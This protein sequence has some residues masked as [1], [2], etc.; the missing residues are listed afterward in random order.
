MGTRHSSAFKPGEAPRKRSAAELVEVRRM[1]AEA[2]SELEHL[3]LTTDVACAPA[4]HIGASLG[5][6]VD[7]LRQTYLECELSID[8]EDPR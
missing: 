8:R 2:H 7:E 3:R 4:K 6:A 5:T 1:L